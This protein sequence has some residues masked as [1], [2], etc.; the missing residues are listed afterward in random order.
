MKI[1]LPFA[2]LIAGAGVMQA[3]IVETISF[4]LSSIHAG[5]KL[6]GTFTLPN[7]PAIGDT[8]IAVL[9]FSDPAD[10]SPTSLTTTITVSTGTPSGFSVL[11]SPLSFTNL[12][13]ST[14]PINTR[15]ISLSGFA[16]AMCGSFP[17]SSSGGFQDRSPAVFSATYTIAPAAVP[18]PGYTLLLSL[19]LGVVVFGR[20]AGWSY[21]R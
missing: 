11:F 13:G 6:S 8:A 18:E 14:L 10:Y 2:I 15:D 7:S 5:S 17:C 4:D 21:R 20:G 19:L 16:F 12:S 1:A 3:A 9:S